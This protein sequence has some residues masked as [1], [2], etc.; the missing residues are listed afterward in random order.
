MQG[1]S[2][3]FDLDLILMAIL[4]AFTAAFL[5]DSRSYNLTAALFPR[6][7]STISLILI[8]W[9]ITVRCW[10]LFHKTQDVSQSREELSAKQEG[11]MVWYIS[12]VTMVSYYLLIHI[13]GFTLVTLIYLLAL[14]LLL[15]YKKYK[16]VFITGILWTAG[17]LYVFTYILHARLPEGLMGIFFKWLTSRL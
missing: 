15:G 1:H 3:I 9:T 6:L 7:I 11:S 16:I 10:K 14:P 4:G 17:F 5:I 8:L 13:L 2:R 12:L